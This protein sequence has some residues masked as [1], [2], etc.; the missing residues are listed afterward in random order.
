MATNI[1]LLFN[2]RCENHFP[3][4]DKN[5]LHIIPRFAHYCVIDRRIRESSS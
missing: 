3:S 2:E 4:P 1:A 5:L